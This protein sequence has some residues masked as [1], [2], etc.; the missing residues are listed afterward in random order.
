MSCIDQYLENVTRSE[1]AELGGAIRPASPIK[2]DSA[3]A[4]LLVMRKRAELEC[5]MSRARGNGEKSTY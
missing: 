2:V 5:L 4:Q 1:I 3:P